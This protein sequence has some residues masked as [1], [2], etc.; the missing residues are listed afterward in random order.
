MHKRWKTVG[1]VLLT[2]LGTVA[3]AM[4]AQPKVLV[5]PKGT[6]TVFWRHVAAG[7]RQAGRELDITVTYRGPQSEDQHAAQIQI[8]QF[9]IRQSYDAI[10]LA[11][12]HVDAAG[13][14]LKAAVA[15][16]V[17]VVLI[18]SNMNH[19][20]HACFIESN[21]LKAGHKAADE[22]AARLA[23]E[24]GVALV[25]FQENHAS[26]YER[27]SGFLERLRSRHPQIVLTADERGGVSVGSAYHAVLAL[28]TRFPEVDAIFAV[29]ESTTMG[30]LK[31]L[32]E[33]NLL[34]KVRFVGFDFNAAIE[35]A[36]RK[37]EMNATIVQN[38][39]QMGYLGVT[40]AHALIQGRSV[41]AKIFTETDLVTTENVHTA[42]I[43]K[44][45]KSEG[46]PTP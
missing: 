1:C 2:L 40:T 21:N 28:L 42:A 34:G 46:P 24:G 27:A 11:P 43:V 6:E 13:P 7:A 45:F 14:A 36:I 30:T 19:H 16:G 25:R 20:Y 32:R 35:A 41:P 33:R 15:Q 23:G 29:N 22:V 17:K 10:V 37:G 8:I 39:F 26:T 31:A 4:G 12:N 18:D 44:Q 3:T 5:I 38:P 9:G